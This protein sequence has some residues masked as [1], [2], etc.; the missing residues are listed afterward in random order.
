MQLRAAALTLTV[1]LAACASAPPPPPAPTALA[2]GDP[3]R[4]DRWVTV[5]AGQIVETR[6][7]QR[8]DVDGLAARL[9]GA[10]LVL[11]GESHAE[12][13]VQ[14]DERQLLD[15]LARRGRRVMVGLEM[16][17][18]AVQPA[19]DRWVAGEGTEAELIRSSHWYRHWGF[20]F[21]HYRALFEFARQRRAPMVALNVEREVITA[22]RKTGIESLAPADRAK[23]PARVDL[24]SAEH[25]R[26]FAAFMGG[27]H[28]GLT[29]ADLDGMFRA[30]C[31][32]DAV[33]A[34]NAVK[35]LT[36]DPDPRAVLVVVAGSG[37]VVYGLGIQR[38]AALWAR[39]PAAAVVSLPAVDDQGRPAPARASVADFVWGA[40]PAPDAPVFP[41]LGASL[42]DRPGAAGPAVTAVRPGSAGHRAGL[43]R[44]DLIVALDRQA[45]ADKEALLILLGEKA[46]GDRVQ[47][48]ILRDGQRRTL[49][50]HLEVGRP[51]R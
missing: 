48:E 42:E 4:R 39:E 37:H 32:W 25:R 29:G 30:Q 17:P 21:G 12:V 33:M 36:A 8:L 40:P 3:A 9:D 31:A 24:D 49:T 34:S 16:L 43:A 41:S 15:A 23:L 50:V 46:W 27:G 20:H 14:A 19:L 7:G 13:A 26:L 5:A 35:A 45:I 47:M 10:R 11:F 44:G 22:V 51:A 2:L 1:S 6:G 28:G 18:A 38:Q